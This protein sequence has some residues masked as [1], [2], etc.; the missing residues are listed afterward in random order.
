MKLVLPLCT[1]AQLMFLLTCAATQLAKAQTA[2]SGKGPYTVP[3]SRHRTP[4][5]AS[6]SVVMY[7]SAYYGRIAIGSPLQEIDVVFDTGSGHLVV[8]STY[9]KSATCI[10]HKRYKKRAS[11]SA[12]DINGDGTIVQPGDARDQISVTFGTG[13]ISG[14]F[15]HD[16]VCLGERSAT[17]APVSNMLLQTKEV[18]STVASLSEADDTNDLGHGC[19]EVALVAATDMSDDPFDGFA[20]DGV[21]G[22]GL[23][24]LSETPAFNFFDVAAETSAW[25][26]MPGFERTFSLFLG[27]SDSEESVITFGGYHPEHVQDNAPF[28]WSHVMNHEDGY[29][30]IQIFGVIS[31]G[32]KLDFCDDGTCRG[33]VD[34]GTSLLAVPTKL[35][36]TLVNDLRF[37]NSPGYK[38]DGPGPKLEL[39][40]GNLTLELGPA[41]FARPEFV[42]EDLRDNSSCIPM[43]MHLDLEEPLSKKT[44]ILGEPVF[45]KYYVAFHMDR[46]APSVGFTLAKHSS[47]DPIV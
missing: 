35:G 42:Q 20:F 25:S 30:Q 22:L 33:V 23:R 13:E 46:E 37:Q 39:D 4:L 12:Q 28:S 45:H 34:S 24:A 14:V 43:V 2:E 38:C 16:I 3:L 18:V 9:C 27:T 40:L 36:P 15:V 29:W 31:N 21:L 11:S 7:R 5:D 17:E 32:V 6:G 10:K 47:R 19:L 41:D 1:W 26:S 8:P 44:F